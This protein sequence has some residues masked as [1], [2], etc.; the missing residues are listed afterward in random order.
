MAKKKKV[1][2]NWKDE[3]IKRAGLN[4][5]CWAVMEELKLDDKLIVKH[6][7]TGEVKVISK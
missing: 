7:I 6:K 1:P 4:P 3:A 5:L 2:Y